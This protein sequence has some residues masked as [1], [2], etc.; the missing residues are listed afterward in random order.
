MLKNSDG[1]SYK[2]NGPNPLSKDQV[3]QELI[4]HNWTW[5]FINEEA[6]KPQIEE[7]IEEPIAEPIAEPI[8]KELIE[9]PEIK[10]SEPVIPIT[11]SLKGERKLLKNMVLVHCLPR[12][13]DGFGKKFIFEA[14][15]IRRESFN[16][17]FWAP[18]KII[19]GSIIYP[20]VYV[21]GG[22]S[23]GDYQWWKID[24]IE[25]KQQ[26]FL[27]SGMISDIQPDFS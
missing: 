7:P 17:I 23:Y 12:T 16:I 5:D 18:I 10:D 24:K 13:N 19:I 9:P 3:W 4:L 26:G 1:S 14:V 27:V 22:N 11:S 15:I 8:I 6:K 25:P 20:S 2:L 21:D